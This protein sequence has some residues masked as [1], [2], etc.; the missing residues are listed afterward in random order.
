MKKPP[1]T[2]TADGFVASVASSLLRQRGERVERSFAHMYETGACGARTCAVMET[3][4][5]DC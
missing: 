1:S 5:N 4:S 2:P 3:F